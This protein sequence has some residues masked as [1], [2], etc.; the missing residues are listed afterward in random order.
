MEL[1]FRQWPF[2]AVNFSAQNIQILILLL[3]TKVARYLTV[4]KPCIFCISCF[5]IVH[6]FS[7]NLITCSLNLI[8]RWRLMRLWC[9]IRD[10]I[11]CAQMKISLNARNEYGAH[12]VW[13]ELPPICILPTKAD[14]D[15]SD[16][17]RAEAYFSNCKLYIPLFVRNT[18]LHTYIN[19][20]TK[21]DCLIF[22]G[23]LNFV[24]IVLGCLM[25]L[26]NRWMGGWLCQSLPPWMLSL[27][28]ALLQSFRC[29]TVRA[30]EWE[31]WWTFF[32]KLK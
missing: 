23:S 17:R 25:W 10:W 27:V 21:Y 18:I 14:S 11:I 24:W 5:F 20:T 29:E 22:R 28:C 1:Y 12:S 6:D 32:N 16:K 3:L 26:L 19:Y 7:S 8:S 2:C 15:L 30:D 4:Y 9:E 13:L 31:Q